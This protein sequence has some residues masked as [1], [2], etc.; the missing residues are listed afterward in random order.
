[1][2]AECW[3]CTAGSWRDVGVLE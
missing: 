2:T 3:L 1:V